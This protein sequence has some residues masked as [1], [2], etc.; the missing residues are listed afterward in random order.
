MI[1]VFSFFVEIVEQ[2]PSGTF[3]FHRDI[4]M[5]TS[6]ANASA[7][8]MNF[9]HLFPL[10]KAFLMYSHCVPINGDDDKSAFPKNTS[11]CEMLWIGD[12]PT[13][14]PT[15]TGSTEKK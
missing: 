11:R 3:F 5:H 15:S 7:L 12:Y 10:I 8:Y 1:F 2:K 6:R 14:P 13:N 9:W 4:H